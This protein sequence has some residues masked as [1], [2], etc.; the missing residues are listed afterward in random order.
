LAKALAGEESGPDLSYATTMST[1]VTH[2][3]LILGTPAYMSPE[4]SR[5][6][7]V[8]KRTDIWAFGCVLYELLTGRAPFTGE[9]LSDTI[10]RILEREPEWRLLPAGTPAGIHRLLQRCLQKDPKQRLHDIADARIEL[11]EART[12]RQPRGSIVGWLQHA[13]NRRARP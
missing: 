10:A 2:E 4:Q 7:A 5:G 9:T 13:F 6:K 8:D 1:V 11:D 12:T 3:G